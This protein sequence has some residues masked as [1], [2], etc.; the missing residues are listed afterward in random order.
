M[1]V[2]GKLENIASHG[3]KKAHNYLNR[4]TKDNS[5]IYCYYQQ[6]IDDQRPD[7]L[8]FSQEIGVVLIIIDDYEQKTLIDVPSSD[9]WVIQNNG[10][11]KSVI[12]PINKLYNILKV[13]DR[14]IKSIKS[15]LTQQVLILPNIS[16]NS[17]IVNPPY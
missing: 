11:E 10:V 5:N 16:E 9:D 15:N 13:V 1:A 4:L 7:F 12:N 17:K 14:K 6:N 3:E 8:L 2:I